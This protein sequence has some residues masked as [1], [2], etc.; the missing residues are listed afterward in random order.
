MWARSSLTLN[1]FFYVCGMKPSKKK[2]KVVTL[3]DKAEII[4]AVMR[5]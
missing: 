1:T 3:D 5:G 4:H 2:E